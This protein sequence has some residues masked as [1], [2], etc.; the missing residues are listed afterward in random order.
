MQRVQKELTQKSIKGR[1][2][3]R[4]SFG[5]GA[6]IFVYSVKEGNED[7]KNILAQGEDDS[8]GLLGGKGAN[9]AVMKT[10]LGLPVPPLATVTTEACVK[11]LNL[12]ELS[13]SLKKEVEQ[14]LQAGKEKEDVIKEVVM[15]K[16][17]EQTKQGIKDIEKETNRKFGAFD[18]PLLVSVRSGAKISMPGMMD[19]VLN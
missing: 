1:Q 13:E 16:V 4:L 7:L 12:K 8:K 17:M 5:N 3:S 6:P 19:T 2:L 15:S 14:E 10:Q 11:Y 9:L 18:N